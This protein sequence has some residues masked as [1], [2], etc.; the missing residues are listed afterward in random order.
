MTS[1]GNDPTPDPDINVS[2]NDDN[3]A[4]IAGVSVAT[5]AITLPQV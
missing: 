3:D 2:D 4:L 1:T 5:A